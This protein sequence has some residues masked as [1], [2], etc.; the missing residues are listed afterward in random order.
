MENKETFTINFAARDNVSTNEWEYNELKAFLE[1]L[2]EL[3]E[4]CTRD[5]LKQFGG[6]IIG[7]KTLINQR[8]IKQMIFNKD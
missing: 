4:Q 2:T 5:E 6:D 1:K 8:M 7:V 3:Q